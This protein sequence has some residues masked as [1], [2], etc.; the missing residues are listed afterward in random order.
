[1]KK[2]ITLAESLIGFEFKLK[3]LDG[4]VYNIYTGR[5]EIL[6]DKQKKVVRGLGMPFFKDS[7]SYGNLIIEIKIEM[8]KRGELSK[9]Q[10]EQL[11]KL[12]PGKINERPKDNSYSMLEDFDKENVNTSEEG[13]HKNVE[14]Q[15]QEEQSGGCRAQ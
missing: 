4:T 13:G 1:M 3:H 15:E 12:L 6:S 11:A 5:G 7:M 2:T 14:E 9:Q 8:P 10:L